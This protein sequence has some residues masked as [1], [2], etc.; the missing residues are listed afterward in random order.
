MKL[1]LLKNVRIAGESHP[2]GT[3]LEVKDKPLAAQLVVAGQAT[4][5]AKDIKAAEAATK[6]AKTPDA[7]K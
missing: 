6:S 3:V 4:D 1:K 7:D 2:A 5:S